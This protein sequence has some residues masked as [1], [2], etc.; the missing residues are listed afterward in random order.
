MVVSRPVFSS[1]RGVNLVL[2][3]L[4]GL[5]LV[6]VFA[7]AVVI[8]VDPLLKAAFIYKMDTFMTL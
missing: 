6:L 8:K 3:Y 2:R 5:V 4:A 1:R 7:P